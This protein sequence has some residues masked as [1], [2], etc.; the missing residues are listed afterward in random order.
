[1]TRLPASTT[2]T[3]RWPVALKIPPSGCDSSRSLVSAVLEVALLA[4]A[5]LN[6]QVADHQPGELQA[7][8]AQRVA[9]VVAQGLSLLLA[10]V[11]HVDFEQDMRATLQVEPEYDVALRPLRPALHGLRGKEV[12]D[13]EQADEQRR[14]QRRDRLPP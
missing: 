10:H 1:M 7:C 5:H 4:D 2:S 6:G 8:A 11:A 12:R 13:G 3:E 9:H 14:Q